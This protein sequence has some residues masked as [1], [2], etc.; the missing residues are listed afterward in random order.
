MT[1]QTNLD[2][3][4]FEPMF[5]TWAYKIK[6]FFDSSGF[7]G[8]YEFLKKES[9]RGISIAPK[10]SNTFRVFQETDIA[11][12]KTIIVGLSPYHTFYNDQPI[13][14]GMCMSCSITGQLQPSLS[15]FYNGIEK[16][17]YDGLSLDGYKNPDLTFLAKQGVVLLNAALTTSK[18][19]PGDHLLLWE[20]FMAYLFRE[21]FDVIRVPVIFLGKEAAKLEKYVDP[22]TWVFKISHPASAAY[23]GNEWN[24]EGTFRKVNKILHDTNGHQINWLDIIP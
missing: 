23:S 10:S 17:L 21:V 20:P 18:N 11:N 16:D 4:S 3:K 12:V 15:Q 22:Y 2:W 1:Q 5:G 6:P 9:R 19:K 8:I 14:D 13:A 24:P 7:D